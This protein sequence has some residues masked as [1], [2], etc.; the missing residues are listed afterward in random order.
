MLPQAGRYQEHCGDPNLDLEKV[1]SLMRDTYNA[2]LIHLSGI[3]LSEVRYQHW[4]TIVHLQGKIYDVLGS[5]VGRKFVGLPSEEISCLSV[6]TFSADRVIV[7]S[8]LILQ[9]DQMIKKSADIRSVLERRML[10]WR[11]ERGLNYAYSR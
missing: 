2:T 10:M 5:A 3:A 8:L 1:H 7:F 11:R 4:N 6:A 9:R